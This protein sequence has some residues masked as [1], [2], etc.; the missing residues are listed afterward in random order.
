M[1]DNETWL[2]VDDTLY[3]MEAF[4]SVRLDARA[5]TLYARI[6]SHEH[7][8]ALAHGESAA[9]AW[10]KIREAAPTIVVREPV[11]VA[12][13]AAPV[14]IGHELTEEERAE[15]ARAGRARMAAV[16]ALDLLESARYCTYDDCPRSLRAIAR[17]G[18]AGQ[19]PPRT[20]VHGRAGDPLKAKAPAAP[21]GQPPQG[22]AETEFPLAFGLQNGPPRDRMFQGTVLNV[23]II[24]GQVWTAEQIAA[25]VAAGCKNDTCPVCTPV[26]ELPGDR[27]AT[28]EAKP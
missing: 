19:E 28:L 7:S 10:R 5:G 23:R 22:A 13:S 18:L 25:H 6:P 14:T 21:P 20:C 11:P 24:P 16:V 12:P 17:A 15:A 3:N 4:E 8:I 27:K 2:L 1:N 9:R 26:G